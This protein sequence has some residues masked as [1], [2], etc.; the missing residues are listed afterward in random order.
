MVD[1]A[2]E[3]GPSCDDRETRSLRVEIVRTATTRKDKER[4]QSE[5]DRSV[6]VV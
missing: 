1:D 4:V 2:L 6:N 3:I 5:V